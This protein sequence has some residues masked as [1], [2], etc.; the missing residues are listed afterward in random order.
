MWPHLGRK[1]VRNVLEFE[2][3]RVTR[4]SA[5]LRMTFTDQ[6]LAQPRSLP[7]ALRRRDLPLLQD[8]HRSGTNPIT[9]HT[10]GHGPGS[11]LHRQRRSLL[12]MGIHLDAAGPQLHAAGRVAARGRRNVCVPAPALA[13]RADHRVPRACGDSRI[14]VVVDDDQSDAA[15]RQNRCSD[16]SRIRSRSSMLAM[17]NCAKPIWSNRARPSPCVE[18]Q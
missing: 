9:R 16:S 14:A 8:Q 11:F 3:G 2:V 17:K 7:Q 6:A 1:Y 12:R 18:G 5:V 15:G 4:R 13:D 10:T